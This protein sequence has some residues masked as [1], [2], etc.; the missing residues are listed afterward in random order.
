MIKMKY[1]TKPSGRSL[2]DPGFAVSDPDNGDTFV[3][4][5]DCAGAQ[6]WVADQ[7]RL[8]SRKKLR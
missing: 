6:G 3:C 4:T 8:I 2:T 7:I 1:F 5:M